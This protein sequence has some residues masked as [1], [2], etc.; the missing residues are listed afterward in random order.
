MKVLS[1]IK[2]FVND[3]I[4]PY[5]LDINILKSVGMSSRDI[6]KCLTTLEGWLFIT[7]FPTSTWRKDLML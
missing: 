3:Q 6:L 2:L 5:I 7:S 4:V 1:I